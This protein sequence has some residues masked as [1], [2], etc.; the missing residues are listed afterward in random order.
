MDD[1]RIANLPESIGNL[2]ALTELD[3]DDNRIANLP[4][5]IGNLT[6]LTTLRVDSNWLTSLPESIG[7]LT[8]LTTLNLGYNQIA[9]LPRQ[10]ANLLTTGLYLHLSGNPLADPLP[11]IVARGADSLAAYLRSLED[12]IALFEA[13][14]LVVG[15]GNVGKTSLVAAFRGTSFVNDRPTTHGIQISPLILQHP[16]LDLD[17]T[18]R[19][20]DFGGQEVYRVSHQFF[21]TRRAL[22]LV[23]WNPREGQEQDEVEGWLRRRI[24]LRV[25]RNAH[26]L[27][28][29]TH[30]EDR[31]PEL[32]YPQLR[33]SRHAG[34]QFRSE[35]PN[36]SRPP[37]ASPGDRPAGCAP[38]PDG[39]ADQPALGGRSRRD[40]NSRQ[41][42]TSDSVRAICG[43]LRKPR[44]RRSRNHDP[45]GAY[46]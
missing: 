9:N 24:R 44:S 27:L 43:G 46:A 14:L 19:A 41:G 7:N 5:S 16:N 18:L 20:W 40:T 4:E 30:C 38:T 6:A 39:P 34:R 42:R 25:G 45:R 22:Y 2:T 17:M 36:R 33:R 10:L 37:E 32:D 21:F 23:V 26:I 35:Q 15:E 1:N 28:A 31:L 11:E 8:A 3:L 13:K 12:A 29:A